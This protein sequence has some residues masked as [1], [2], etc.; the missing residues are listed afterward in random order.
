MDKNRVLE[1]T[2]AIPI[3]EWHTLSLD[4]ACVKVEI[5]LAGHSMQPLIRKNKDFVT[6]QPMRRKILKGDI[7]LFKNIDGRYIVHRVRKI[8]ID[9]LQTMGDNCTQPDREI[10]EN[11]ILGYVTHIHRGNITIFVDTPIWRLFG[12]FWLSIHPLRRLIRK[13]FIPF[14]KL[15]R[16]IIR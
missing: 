13:I 11:E 15:F 8:N 2:I 10:S 3:D 4:D 9:K 16:G 12:C 6:I 14:K 5:Q 1:K 7:V